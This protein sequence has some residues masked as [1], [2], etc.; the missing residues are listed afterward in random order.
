MSMHIVLPVLAHA[1]L[2]KSV[3]WC[4]SGKVDP[5][6]DSRERAALLW[7]MQFESGKDGWIINPPHSISHDI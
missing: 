7:V 1:T 3:C 4:T 6:S 2:L 5:N